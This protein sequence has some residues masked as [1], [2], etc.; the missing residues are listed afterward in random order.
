VIAFEPDADFQTGGDRSAVARFFLIAAAVNSALL[1]FIAAAA[2]WTPGDLLGSAAVPIMAMLDTL[3]LAAMISFAV[4]FRR[5]YGNLGHL[6]S[7]MTYAPDMA[8]ALFFIPLAN[9]VAPQAAL[10]ELSTGKDDES[11]GVTWWFAFL[12]HSAVAN[13]A[14]ILFA[15]STHAVAANAALAVSC[16]V[17]STAAGLAVRFIETIDTQQQRRRRTLLSPARTVRPPVVQQ[18]KVTLR[19][20]VL[21]VVSAVERQIAAEVPVVKPVSPP[22]PAQSLAET[23]P[24][25][26]SVLRVL[27][28]IFALIALNRAFEFYGWT[29]WEYIHNPTP[30]LERVLR[31]GTIQYIAGLAV[32]IV[33]CLWLASAYP[34]AG[35]T[36]RPSAMLFEFVATL[37]SSRILRDTWNLALF[38]E[39]AGIT[40]KLWSWSWRLLQIAI[41]GSFVAVIQT[42]AELALDVLCTMELIAVVTAILTFILVKRI[43]VALG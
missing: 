12:L 39:P 10:R 1:L 43:D 34:A 13:V 6:D 40:V 21:P 5:A 37:G 14:T 11:I 42:T 33:F 17:G 2:I 3:E 7:Q 24:W 32:A 35:G 23:K 20:A 30:L 29:K 15:N 4:W 38:D 36:K 25:I 31:A 19:E 22:L 16:L 26:G 27:L 28:V 8:A 41:V 9:F 18:P